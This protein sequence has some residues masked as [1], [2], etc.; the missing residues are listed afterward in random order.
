MQLQLID[1]DYTLV[2]GRPLIRLFGKTENDETVCAMV[3]GYKPYFYLLPKEE[4]DLKDVQYEFEKGGVDY[5]IVDRYLPIGWYP[6][7]VKMIKVIGRDPSKIPELRAW[8]TKFGTPYEADVLFKYRYMVDNALR[9]M[10]WFD[11]SGKQATTTTVKCKAIHA[12]SI[13]PIE[14]LNN[15]PLRYLA[16]DIECAPQSGLPNADDDPIIMISLV[17]TPEWRGKKSVVL[18]SKSTTLQDCIGAHTEEDMLKK[19]KDIL[20]DYDPDILTGYNITNF[21]LPYILRRLEVLNLPRDL[22]RNDKSAWVRKLANTQAITITGR[23]VVDSYDLIK[24]DPWVKL[25][26]YDLKTVAKS[27]LGIE[28]FDMSGSAEITKLWKG[29]AEDLKRLVEYNRRDSELAMKLLTERGVLDKFFEIAK[30]SGLLLQDALGGQS[31]RH[32][33][34]LLYEFK[35]RHFV[36]PCRPDSAEIMRRK[37]EREETGLKG[38]LVLEPETGLHKTGCVLVLDFT[39]LYPSLI[40]VFNICPT[41]MVTNNTDADYN[42]T[43]FGTK[44]VKPSV[45]EGVLPFVVRE[46]ITTRAA[47]RAQAKTETDKE[48]KRILNAKQLALKD[49]ANSLYGYTGFAHGRIYVMDIANSI[50][51]YGR[52]MVMKTKELIEANFPYKVIYADTDSSFVKTDILDL[53]AAQDTGIKIAKFVT[54]RLPGLELKYEKLFKTFLIE[55]KKRYAGWSFEKE[56][57]GWKEKID[58]KGIETVR[59][60]WCILTSDT[61]NRVIDIILREGDVKKAARFVREVIAEI[62]AGKVPLEKLAVVKGITKDIDSYD[63]VQPHVELA[64]KMAARDN[65]K[66][67]MV[68]ERLEYVIVKGNALLSKR[69]EDPR[70]VK[71]NGLEI[72]SHYYIDNQILPPLERIFEAAGVTRTELIHGTKQ[73]S[74]LSVLNGQPPVLSPEKTTLNSY[75][76][77]VCKKCDWSFRRPTLT[78]ACPTCGGQLFFSNG[79][80]LGKF[81]NTTS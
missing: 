57:D 47:V 73:M 40:R 14:V 72:D 23:V 11:V 50:T 26:R 21:D 1:A 76:A 54:E 53:D 12:S 13:K 48:K 4:L 55:T 15:A 45:R 51:A 66:R 18:L 62:A 9:G 5:E 59:R 49:M 71:E 30:V 70:F 28:K 10:M 44:F 46:L 79:V 19:F 69:A 52:E 65:T 37:T 63:G 27:L 6:N 56:E 38:A 74:L 75:D 29:S 32:E 35:Q 8:S 61:M 39:S 3:D 33:C 81:I 67:N 80:S 24:R 7:T 78:G 16:F 60:D 31:T 77:V 58:M 41:T 43:P 42:T 22:G 36:M 25:K 68:G 20:D 34:K 17:F 2:N 64:K